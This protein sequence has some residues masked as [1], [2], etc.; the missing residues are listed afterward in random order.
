MSEF[1]LVLVKGNEDG[2]I[3]KK[4]FCKECTERKAKV[5]IIHSY[6][7]S[8]K[9]ISELFKSVESYNYETKKYET[10]NWKPRLLD[11]TCEC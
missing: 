5:E 10:N 2:I 9:E 3:I 6:P 11:I 7:I 8:K 4:P 1:A